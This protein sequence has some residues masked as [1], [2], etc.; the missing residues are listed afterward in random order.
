MAAALCSCSSNAPDLSTPVTPETAHDRLTS[1]DGNTFLEEI[2]TYKWSDVGQAAASY[3]DWIPRE[4]QPSDP[5]TSQQ[6]GE[7]AHTLAV[8]LADHR[9]TLEAVPDGL[10]G[11]RKAPV[12]EVNP[13]LVAAYGAALI[14]YLPAIAGSDDS[15]GFPPFEH[16]TPEDFAKARNVFAVIAT[17]PDSGREFIDQ[18][19]E[20]AHRIAATA[21]RDACVPVSAKKV[22]SAVLRTAGVLASLADSMSNEEDSPKPYQVSDDINFTMAAACV[23]AD[24]PPS[25]TPTANYMSSGKLLTPQ[26]VLQQRNEGLADYYQSLRDYLAVRDIE[27]EPYLTRYDKAKG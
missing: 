16:S 19:R 14:P 23:A 22:D 5:T 26:E 20:D 1:S 15:P 25:S 8:F 7:T 12:G 6:A 9:E 11:V 13:Q 10:F 24:P 17:N 2:S 3:F 21:T 4:A 18:A 27:I